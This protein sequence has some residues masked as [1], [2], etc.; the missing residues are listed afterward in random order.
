MNRLAVQ[1]G[2]W[3]ALT[4]ALALLGFTVCFIVVFATSPLFFWTDLA[5]YLDYVA[6]N[7]RV[8]ADVARVFALLFAVS[9]VV[10]LNAVHEFVPV[11]RRILTRIS[12]AFGLLF[13][14]MISIHYFVQIT[15]VR[16]SI[17]AGQTAGLE[18]VVQANP[19]SAVAAI[20]MLGWTLFL[21][22]SSL[23]LVPLFGNGRLQKTIKTAFLVNGI[24]C[25]LAGVSYIFQWL[26]ILF[27]TINLGM[28]GAVTV[29][30]F[31]LAIFFR[32]LGLREL[33]MA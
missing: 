31:A 20:N 26:I 10:T 2:F 7:G 15:A 24:C 21:G 27:V 18:Q 29:A 30:M 6:E 13:A 1:I 11:E 23:F 17:Q 33:V 12:L 4:S 8:W 32:R 28:G 25:L 9:F 22:V 14:G 16:L 5:D 3:S 19:I